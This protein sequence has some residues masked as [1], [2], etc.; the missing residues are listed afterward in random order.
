MMKR[1]FA[2]VVVTASL[3]GL[4]GCTLGY[5]SQLAG[6]YGNAYKRGYEATRANDFERAAGQFEAAAKS[7][8]PKALVTYGRL[9][10]RGQ[11]VE[12]DPFRAAQLFEDAYGKKSPFKG[13]AALELGLLLLKGGDG[14]SGTVPADEKRAIE[15]LQAALD[16]GEQRAAASLA[17]AYD[18]GL[19]VEADPEKAIALY[20]EAD[21]GN[22]YAARDLAL[23]LKKAGHSEQQVTSAAERAIGLFETQA[24]AGDR[25]AWAQLAEI[26]SR[27]EIVDADADRAIE[28]LANLDEPADAPMQK[29]LARIY[30]RL[31]E[32]RDRN[33]MLRLAADSGDVWAQTQLARYF[34]KPGTAD[35]N[36]EV[37]RYYAERAI[38]KGDRNAMVYLGLAMLR[39]ETVDYEPAFGESLLRRA[40]DGGELRATAALGT[41]ILRG[42]VT[43]RTAGEGLTLL[44]SA[45]EKGSA[46]AMSTLGFAYFDGRG[47]PQDEALGLQWI[48]KAANAG[49]TRAKAFLTDGGEA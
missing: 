41:A 49:S 46:S 37:G 12:A 15:L 29:Q 38:G 23:L 43:E 1:H 48:E 32:R 10:A 17:R 47:L 27:N 20:Q 40:H 11:G 2:V 30:D 22:A 4:T 7:G 36:G 3:A 44:E 45:A 16:L 6:S 14:P 42:Q 26:Y 33:R 8:H 21:P 25:K 5:S 9:L 35:T 13:K 18:R 24:K 28:Y 31:G 39:G 19:G 34:L